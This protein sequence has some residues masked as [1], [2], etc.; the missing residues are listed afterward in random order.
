MVHIFIN[1]RLCLCAIFDLFLL[2]YL[3]RNPFG[4]YVNFLLKGKSLVPT[5]FSP[6]PFR[7]YIMEISQCR[8]NIPF[9]LYFHRLIFNVVLIIPNVSVSSVDWVAL[10]RIYYTEFT[11][12]VVVK[13]CVVSKLRFV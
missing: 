12:H 10:Q 5:L 4:M 1:I 3:E 8:K 13:V 11:L 2:I 9:C 7:S 6:C